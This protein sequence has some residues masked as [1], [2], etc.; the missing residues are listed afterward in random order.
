M[1]KLWLLA[2]ICSICA[3][4]QEPQPSPAP[5]SVSAPAPEVREPSAA[6][7]GV[8]DRRPVIACFGDSLTAGQGLDPGQ[9]YPDLLQRELDQRHYGYRVANF[10]VSGDTT[11][12]GL[13]RLSLVVEDKP[14]IV[15]LELGAND[16]LRGQ[17]V[18]N[19]ESNLARM[20]EAFQ[21]AGA[22]VVLAGITLPPN[23]GPDYIHR[24]DAMYRNL[25]G[26]YQVKRI[27]F[28]LAGVGGN[29]QLMQ[30]DGLHPNAEGTK[31][32][33]RTVL[34]ALVPLLGPAPR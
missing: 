29:T 14:A 30:R 32:V 10:G 1:K 11:Q 25:A 20:I 27:P 28:L 23:Y 21:T 24:F 5:G 13:A 22:R 6:P 16:G 18:S 26:K 3:C 4:R 2:A 31:V 33:A 34:E 17:P 8:A 12:D 19:S 7:A 9:S 15:V